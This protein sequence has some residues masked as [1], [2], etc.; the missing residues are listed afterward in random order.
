MP[1]T[2]IARWL[3]RDAVGGTGSWRRRPCCGRCATSM[4][5]A[6]RRRGPG[7]CASCATPG[8]ISARQRAEKVCLWTR[9]EERARRPP[10]P[11]IE[12]AGGR[13]APAD[14][15]RTRGAARRG[16]RGPG[17][18]RDRGPFVQAHRGGARPAV[19]HRH[20]ATRTGAREIGGRAARPPGK[21][22]P[23]TARHVRQWSTPM[24]TASCRRA[25]APTSSGVFR[26][27]RSVG[28]G[29]RRRGR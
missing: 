5:F 18:A 8:S 14:R 2:A 13:P 4:P 22:R 29:S 24:S 15:R 6:A 19:R 12:R 1:P 27:A 26:A 23:W 9:I 7:C 21:E 28:A 17:A 11:R 16:A 10:R 20:V 25:K 3:T